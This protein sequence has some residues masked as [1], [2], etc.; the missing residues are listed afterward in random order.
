VWSGGKS[1][2]YF[3]GLPITIRASYFV[4]LFGVH[5]DGADLYLDDFGDVDTARV[6]A[7]K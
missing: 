7:S 3:K 5:P 1:C 2:D 6:V 4:R